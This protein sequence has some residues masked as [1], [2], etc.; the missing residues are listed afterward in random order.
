MMRVTMYELRFR[1]SVN[2]DEAESAHITLKIY[3]RDPM[4]KA[5]GSETLL[6]RLQFE[7][8]RG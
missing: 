6:K 3:Q 4:T 5:I 2:G 8:H 7:S 1:L